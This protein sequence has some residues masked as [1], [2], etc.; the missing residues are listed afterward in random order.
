VKQTLPLWR[1][2][3]YR[4]VVEGDFKDANFKGLVKAMEKI[5]DDNYGGPVWAEK[6]WAEYHNGNW[7]FFVHLY[8]KKERVEF[9]REYSE[10]VIREEGGAVKQGFARALDPETDYSGGL[11]QF[12]E[13]M[14][15]WRNR[16]NSIVMPPPN[17]S[18]VTL[19]GSAPPAI[20]PEVHTAMHKLLV[21]Y[22]VTKDRLRTGR[23]MPTPTL[24]GVNFT[25]LYDLDDAEE[26]KRAK[27]VNE[28]WLRILY[29]EIPG[30]PPPQAMLLY[31]L[32][33]DTAKVEM[34]KLGEYY[35]LL[36]KMKRTLD[37]NRIMNPGHFMDLEPY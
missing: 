34:P 3:E 32:G 15:Y 17:M 35:Q 12:Y 22:G 31:R 1:I 7:E 26:V 2:P 8:G 25:Y 33:P 14:I 23:L 29:K 28:E 30:V 21:K 4:H 6:V 24:L 10:K 19:S 16:A 36:K 11:M 20:L 9:D 37:P 27:A 5:R 18:W 13:E